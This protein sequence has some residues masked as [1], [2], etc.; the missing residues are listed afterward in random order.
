VVP[1]ARLGKTE[2][3]LQQTVDRRRRKEVASPNDVGHALQ[4]VIDNHRQMIAR[5][6]IAS[7]EDNVAPNLRRRRTS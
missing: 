7:A 1:I 4:R 3:R 6:Q 2:Q 5:R